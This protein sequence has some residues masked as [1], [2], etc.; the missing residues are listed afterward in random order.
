MS[1]ENYRAAT[2]NLYAAGADG[3]SAFNYM[4]HWVGRSLDYPP[5]P[6]MY[7]LALTWLREMRN[8]RQ[9]GERSRHYL[10]YPLYAGHW[11]GISPGGVPSVFDPTFIKNDRIA[12]RRRVGSSGE[13]RFRICE[14]LSQPGPLA[15]M[16]VTIPGIAG[17]DN[18][19][20]PRIQRDGSFKPPAKD[21]LAFYVNGTVV[22]PKTIKVSWPSR[23]RSKKYGRP[24]ETCSIFMFPLTSLPTVFGDNM[25]KAEVVALDEQGEGGIIIDQFEVT[26]VPPW[27]RHSN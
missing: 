9:L 25:L 24:F 13:Y 6:A 16:I 3:I 14:D 26:V 18:Q 21:K 7:P 12:L 23:G 11:G 8:P 27:K 4:Y 1:L 20:P 5:G 10:F 15:E 2:R 19:G 22:P 17:A